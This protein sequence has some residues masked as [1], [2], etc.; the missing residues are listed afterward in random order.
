MLIAMCSYLRF[1][2][3]MFLHTWLVD[4]QLVEPAAARYFFLARL[5]P[6]SADHDAMDAMHNG[7][8]YD[9]PRSDPTP[10]G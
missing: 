7:R 4:P 3:D 6:W 10:Y 2:P 9:Y 1:S 8:V 5:G